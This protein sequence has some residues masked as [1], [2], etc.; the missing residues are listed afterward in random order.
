MVY[1]DVP[2]VNCRIFFSINALRM[3]ISTYEEAFHLELC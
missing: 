3:L 1:L 2:I